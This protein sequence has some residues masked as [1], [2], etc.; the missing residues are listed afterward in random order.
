MIAVYSRGGRR[1]CEAGQWW[2]GCGARSKSIRA[3]QKVG[4]AELSEGPVWFMSVQPAF[5]FHALHGKC[6]VMPL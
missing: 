6:T 5:I 2:A 1:G 4:W 3:L